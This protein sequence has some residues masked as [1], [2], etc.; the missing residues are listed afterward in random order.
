VGGGRVDFILFLNKSIRID[1]KVLHT[2]NMMPTKEIN[3]RK[4]KKKKI[5]KRISVG[6][7]WTQIRS[8]KR[9]RKVTSDFHK[10]Y[11][12]KKRILAK[13]DSND[14]SNVKMK[15]ESIET[16]IEQMGGHRAYQSASVLT[17]GRNKTTSRWVFRILDKELKLRPTK[18]SVRLKTLEVGAINCQILSCPWLDVTAIDLNSS[19]PR[20][21]QRDF[22]D[23]EPIK[24]F[25]VLVCAMVLN[26]VPTPHKRG[27]MM[28]RTYAHLVDGGHLFVVLPRRCLAR[29][30]YLD[31]DIFLKMLQGV[32]FELV[33]SDSSPKI[34][35][36][37]LRKVKRLDRDGLRQFCAEPSIVHRGKKRTNDFSVAFRQ[38]HLRTGYRFGSGDRK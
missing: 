32:G 15:I 18:S 20:I 1:R 30:R 38:E 21:L 22:F 4:R 25:E 9:A 6:K 37:C 17:T 27:E 33:R 3:R 35:F 34:D 7:G 23:I 28:L 8:M 36:F 19:H 29:S 31:R 13:Q 11:A 5:A 16:Q 2:I 12:E 24:E 14:S 26:F 10:L